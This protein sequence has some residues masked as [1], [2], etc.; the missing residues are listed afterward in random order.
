MEVEGGGNGGSWD[1]K[2]ILLVDTARRG[3]FEMVIRWLKEVREMENVMRAGE[4]RESGGW[5]VWDLDVVGKRAEEGRKRD[6]GLWRIEPQ[7]GR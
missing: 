5:E 6:W 4:R 7:V 3:D 2:K 1:E